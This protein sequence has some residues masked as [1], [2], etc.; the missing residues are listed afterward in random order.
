MVLSLHSAAARSTGASGST[1]PDSP[2]PTRRTLSRPTLPRPPALGTRTARAAREHLGWI[3]GA[4][5]ALLCAL[6]WYGVSGERYTARQIPFLASATAPGVALI[7]C[8]GV[9]LAARHRGA[10]APRELARLTERLSVLCELLTDASPTGSGFDGARTGSH[11]GSHPGVGSGLRPG[12]GPGGVS[13]DSE[14]RSAPV[15]PVLLAVQGARTY[16]RSDCLLV[17]GR[18]DPEPITSATA[19]ALGLRPCPLCEPPEA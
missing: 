12:P 14:P 10:A 13:R 16:H 9:L 1:M 15:S 3:F 18:Q 6:G 2:D 5:G 11:P 19:A 8:G 17:Q 4:A 7:V